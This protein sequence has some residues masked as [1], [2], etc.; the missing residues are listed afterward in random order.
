MR[1]KFTE[2]IE[3]GLAP[4]R[5]TTKTIGDTPETCPVCRLYNNIFSMITDSH[6]SQTVLPSGECVHIITGALARNKTMFD[7]V[8]YACDYNTI[9]ISRMFLAA[10]VEGLYSLGDL[11]NRMNWMASVE[12][13]NNDNA[14]VLREKPA[15]IALAPV[16]PDTTY[17][18]SESRIPQSVRL[19]T[20]DN[21]VESITECAENCDNL[22]KFADNMNKSV[23]VRG[24]NWTPDIFNESV[25]S[26][27]GKKYYFIK[28][29]HK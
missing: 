3:N 27:D 4:S 19:L 25:Y 22:Y 11:F 8:L 1:N 12:K 5:Y 7:R 21:T 2:W 14:I 9:N 13:V 15:E 23:R 29:N 17:T 28:I 6:M 16:S 26:W 18:T 10:G 20:T 24:N